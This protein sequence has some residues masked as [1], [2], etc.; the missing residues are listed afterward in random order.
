M[1]QR[2]ERRQTD[3]NFENNWKVA[4]ISNLS[5][6]NVKSVSRAHKLSA[7]HLQLRRFWTWFMI[8]MKMSLIINGILRN[9]VPMHFQFF[10]QGPLP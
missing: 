4:N 10:V 8:Y 7:K 1:P 9:S 5:V 2:M 3:Q 6:K